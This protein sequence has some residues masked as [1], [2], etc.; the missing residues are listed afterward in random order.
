V[1][2][3]ATLRGQLVGLDTAPLIYYIET[4][5]TYLPIIDPFF[6][7][8]AAGEIQVVTSTVSLIEV[9]TQPLRSGQAALAAQ[10]RRLLLNSRG[11]VMRDVSPPIAEEAARLRA[12]YA[13]R[14]P[15]AIHLAT[16]INASARMFL[17]NDARLSVVS[18]LDIIVLDGL[19]GASGR[20]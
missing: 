13:L 17:T 18:E 4:H 14:T 9:L 3:L 8:V 10:Y 19:R 12:R 7:A 2:W 6:D 15:D 20:V 11:V 16:T 5:P 1:E